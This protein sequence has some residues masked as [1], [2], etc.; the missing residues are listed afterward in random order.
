MKLPRNQLGLALFGATLVLSPMAASA[1]EKVV[2]E[3]SAGKS[4]RYELSKLEYSVFKTLVDDDANNL[5][6]GNDSLLGERMGLTDT[7]ASELAKAYSDNEVAADKRFKKKPLLINGKIGSINSGIGGAP[8]LALG[9]QPSSPHARLHKSALDFAASAKKGQSVSLIC[10]GAGAT[11]TIPM[12]DDCRPARAVADEEAT[13]LTRRVD[14]VLKGLGSDESA[15][16]LL[17][18]S[19]YA[20]STIKGDSCGPNAA[21]CLKNVKTAMKA[22]GAKEG[23]LKAME[24]LKL[25][26]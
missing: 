23:I 21:A 1:Q 17:A 9:T 4:H 15:Q 7:T 26:G 18:I 22:P 5:A 16:Q 3:F 20:A 2:S 10:T 14:R 19:I 25:A 11:I 6:S 13:K 8:Y 24:T 12:L